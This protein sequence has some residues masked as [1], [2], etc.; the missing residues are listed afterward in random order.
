M[1]P[2]AWI[3]LAAVGC[4]AAG[5]AVGH[6]GCDTAGAAPADAV[7]SS[8]VEQF[9]RD[10]GLDA[11]QQAILLAVLRKGRDAESALQ[12]IEMIDARAAVERLQEQRIR[13]LLTDTQRRL[14]DERTR[15]TNP[16]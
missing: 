2:R 12:G 3:L 5:V 11:R 14:Y 8:Y 7:E 16:K 1:N 15:A 6:A 10:F 13:A 9:T 4:F